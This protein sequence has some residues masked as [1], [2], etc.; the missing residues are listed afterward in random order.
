VGQTH[1]RG[2]TFNLKDL[3]VLPKFTGD[4]R[5]VDEF[6]EEFERLAASAYDDDIQ[7]HRA[8][9][10]CISGHAALALRTSANPDEVA[11]Y[12]GLVSFLYANFG[13]HQSNAELLQ[14]LQSYAAN[15]TKESADAVYWRLKRF[16]RRYN[17]RDD[18]TLALLFLQSTTPELRDHLIRNNVQDLKEMLSASRSVALAKEFQAPASKPKKVNLVSEVDTVLRISEPSTAARDTQ[19]SKDAR[20]HLLQLQASWAHCSSLPRATTTED[21][22]GATSCTAEQPHATTGRCGGEDRTRETQRDSARLI[23]TPCW[24]CWAS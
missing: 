2:A 22:G 18:K 9:R 4:N 23:L 15:E 5:D 17:I 24:L 13:P 20:T 21:D 1:R 11:T 19:T 16:G 3:S 12:D 6:I 14:R 10:A 7:R 8:L